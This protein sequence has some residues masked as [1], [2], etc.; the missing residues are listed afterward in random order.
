MHRD[1]VVPCF[2]CTTYSILVA[3][4]LAA[5]PSIGGAEEHAM[6]ATNPEVVRAS[7]VDLGA[8][9][10]VEAALTWQWLAPPVTSFRVY[11]RGHG[12]RLLVEVYPDS[13]MANIARQRSQTRITYGASSW[14]GNVGLFE[15]HEP[16]PAY[17]ESVD[18]SM[19]SQDRPAASVS[20]SPADDVDADLRAVVLRTLWAIGVEVDQ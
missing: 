17:A 8:G 15:S 10:E 20:S 5:W 13:L 16:Y 7:F 14:L 18:V 19:G 4:L 9:Y 2:R 11:D 6:S 1:S 3:C 12:R